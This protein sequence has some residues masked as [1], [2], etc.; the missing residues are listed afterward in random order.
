MLLIVKII[1]FVILNYEKTQN[2][3][4]DQKIK[5]RQLARKT[6]KRALEIRV[7]VTNTEHLER[8]NVL[9]LLDNFLSELHVLLEEEEDI[10]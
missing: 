9:L 8:E 3:E 5:L 6:K 4:E 7:S 10:L 2:M 1:N